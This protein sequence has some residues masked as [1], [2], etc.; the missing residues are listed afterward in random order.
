MVWI[1]KNQNKIITFFLI[2]VSIF[3]LILTL[4]LINYSN[5]FEEKFSF[6]NII[7]GSTFVCLCFIGSIASIFPRNCGKI[8]SYRGKKNQNTIH[9]LKKSK[10]QGHHYQC[11]NYSNHTLRIRKKYLCATCS[12][13]LT[14][15]ILGI[16]GSIGYF[17]GYLQIEIMPILTF[18]GAACVFFGLFQSIIPNTR[19]PLSRFFAGIL[20]VLGTYILL[21]NLDQVRNSTFADLFFISISIFWIFTKINLSQREHKIV[22][23]NCSEKYC[24]N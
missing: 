21:I 1:F 9:S 8:F 22:C 4:Y 2:L 20:L 11:R 5:N 23:L 15:A 12:G 14:G 24:K 13:F 17:S 7:V 18:L 19:G 3:S 16:I 6:H 10:S